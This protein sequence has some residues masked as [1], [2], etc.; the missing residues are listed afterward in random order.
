[1]LIMYEPF[2]TRWVKRFLCNI[3][4]LCF[5]KTFMIMENISLWKTS[6]MEEKNLFVENILD[7]E[8]LI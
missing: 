3:L 7:E 2:T 8:K 5:E 1:M 4:R 6:L